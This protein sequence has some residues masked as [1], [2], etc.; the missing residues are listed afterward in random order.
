MGKAFATM[1]MHA[2]F[3]LI[4]AMQHDHILKKNVL[5]P[6]GDGAQAFKLKAV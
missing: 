5:C 2:S 1:L 6:P 4:V 3:P